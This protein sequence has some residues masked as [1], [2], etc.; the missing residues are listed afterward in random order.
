MIGSAR[1][2]K[3]KLLRN[4]LSR[5]KARSIHSTCCGGGWFIDS[6]LRTSALPILRAVQPNLDTPAIYSTTHLRSALLRCRIPAP[7]LRISGAMKV[8][9]SNARSNSDEQSQSKPSPPTRRTRVDTGAHLPQRLHRR[10]IR[11]RRQESQKLDQDRRRVPS[12]RGTRLLDRAQGLPARRAPR[13]TAAGY[14]RQQPKR[15]IG[16]A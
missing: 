7:S 8:Q 10:G 3:L 13:S 5:H 4:G 11:E 15:Q 6:S 14:R 16:R 12:Q 9:T 2:T 1:R